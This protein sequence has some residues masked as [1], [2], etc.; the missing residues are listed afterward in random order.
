MSDRRFLLDADVFIRA[1]RQHYPFDLVPG[2][3]KCLEEH[4]K[5]G[6][7]RSI[8]RV[9]DELLRGNDDLADWAKSSFADAFEKTNHSDVITVY[10]Q[11][12][13]WAQSQS[14]LMD[15]ALGDA[16]RTGDQDRL[17]RALTQSGGCARRRGRWGGPRCRGWGFC[18]RGRG[19]R[20]RGGSA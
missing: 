3:W 19:R 15:A 11:I 13:H 5:A 16:A 8:D 7:A 6:R 1:A 12:M 4:A 2:F 18:S 14:R 10:A 20:V 9:R 17:D